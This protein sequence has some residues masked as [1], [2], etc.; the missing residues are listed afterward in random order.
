MSVQ[1]STTGIMIQAVH[2][3]PGQ[4]CMVTEAFSQPY[5]IIT[6]P[7]FSGEAMHII[8][9]DSN[10]SDRECRETAPLTRCV[11][12]QFSSRIPH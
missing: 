9:D 6:V 8:D 4:I 2:L 1:T 10:H 7:F 12:M 5:H 11:Q 3:S